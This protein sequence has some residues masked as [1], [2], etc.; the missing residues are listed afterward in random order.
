MFNPCNGNPC[1]TN[2]L[3]MTSFEFNEKYKDYLEEGYYGLSINI[4][5]VVDY[6][7]KEFSMLIKIPDFKYYQIK[8]KFNMC[9]FYCKPETIDTHTIENNI[10]QIIKEW[11]RS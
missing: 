4:P 1:N 10:N 2:I 6:L 9:R 3:E 11:E 7:D 5:E 8:V